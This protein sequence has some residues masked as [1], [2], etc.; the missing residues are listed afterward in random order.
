MMRV[1]GWQRLALVVSICWMVGAFIGMRANQYNNGVSAAQADMMICMN[2]PNANL[3]QCRERNGTFRLAMIEWYW[4]PI[5]LVT[6][7]PVPLFWLFGWLALKTSRWVR[8]GF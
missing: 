7:V 5:L 4:P 8:A 2:F 6:L 3:Q 1:S